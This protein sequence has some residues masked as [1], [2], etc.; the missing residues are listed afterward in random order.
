MFSFILFMNVQCIQGHAFNTPNEIRN[1]T[2]EICIR[3]SKCYSL[4]HQWRHV[5]CYLSA[6]TLLFQKKENWSC[7]DCKETVITKT[8]KDNKTTN[9]N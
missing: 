1:S 2:L 5:C 4:C 8:N 3:S 9:D 7:K 6:I